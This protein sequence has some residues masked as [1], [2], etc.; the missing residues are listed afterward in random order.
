[1]DKLKVDVGRNL[2]TNLCVLG[3]AGLPDICQDLADWHVNQILGPI[4]SRE[5]RTKT[6][7]NR[8]PQGKMPGENQHGG[9]ILSFL[10]K[11][12]LESYGESLNPPF[13]CQSTPKDTADRHAAL[14]D[15]KIFD[16]FT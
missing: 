10:R 1:M 2:F 3:S 13:F 12:K 6:P 14:E 15:E 16:L 8:N 9:A 5:Q 7:A 11:E 4:A